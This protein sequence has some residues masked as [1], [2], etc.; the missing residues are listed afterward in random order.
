MKLNYLQLANHKSFKPRSFDR[1]LYRF[2]E[3][4]P[5][6]LSWF[7]I[8]AGILLSYY[9]PIWVAI[10]IIS[11]DIYWLLRVVYLSTYLI[12]SFFEMKKNLK[13]NWL[14]EVE[15]L[16]QF[17]H[18]YHLVIFPFFNESFEIVDSSLKSVANSQYPLDK[19]IVVLASEK[20]AGQEAQEICNRIEKKYKKKFGYFLKTVHPDNILKE[21]AGKGSNETWALKT[22]KK[23]FVDKKQIP[24][25]N[26]VVSVFD[27]DTQVHPQF[28]A[29]LA[30]AYLTTKNPTN[31]SYQ[32]IPMFQNNIWDTPALMR[33]IATS[34]TFWQMM[35]QGRPE[36]MATFSSHSMSFRTVVKIGYWQ[37][38]VVS[39]DSRVFWQCLLQYKGEYEVK[40]LLF[41]VS[42]D[43]NLAKSYFTTMKNQYKQQRRWAWGVENLAFTI[44]HFLRASNVPLGK[45]IR[46]S[47]RLI[48]GAHSW[49]TNALLIFLLGWMPLVLGGDRFTTSVIAHNLIPTT[50]ILASLAMIGM[51][52]SAWVNM[53]L[54]P[55]RPKNV[56]K[57]I[58]LFMILQWVFL[59]ITTIFFGAFPALDAQTKLMFGKFMGFWVTE[60]H[61]KS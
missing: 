37:T 22:V 3:I 57:S 14:Q 42:M 47:F 24:Y 46:Y 43:A 31:H 9:K 33:V 12:L 19:M 27:I 13:T 30:H 20:R 1:I 36:R 11:F 59:P 44:W 61:R 23:E 26:I 5:A 18:L 6:S 49:G 56:K 51:F 48:E 45:K 35:E 28:F 34:T 32:P 17:S 52:I 7:T 10:F 38:N 60:K 40:P 50:R 53:L 39:E 58:F 4:L 41:P 2:L 16:P 15:A 8:F 29:R 21:I 54:L 25:E 55:A